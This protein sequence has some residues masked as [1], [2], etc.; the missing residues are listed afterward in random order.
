MLPGPG[1]RLVGVGIQAPSGAGGCREATGQVT[2]TGA[3]AVG[4]SLGVKSGG[5]SWVHSRVRVSSRI[6][7]SA[8]T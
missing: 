3:G 6:L 5:G 7:C 8:W 2:Q 4:L 1:L